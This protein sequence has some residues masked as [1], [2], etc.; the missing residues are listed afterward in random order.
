[1]D[2]ITVPT[3]LVTTIHDTITSEVYDTVTVD[4]TVTVV[5]SETSTV[6]L[7]TFRKRATLAELPFYA[8]TCSRLSH[9]ASACS[10]IGVTA[11]TIFASTPSATLV[12]TVTETSLTSVTQVVETISTTVEDTTITQTTTDATAT[13]EVSV[14]VTPTP[15]AQPISGYLEVTNEDNVFL[16]YPYLAPYTNESTTAV[17]TPSS[18]TPAPP[19]YILEPNGQLSTG[20]QIAGYQLSDYPS[21]MLAFYSLESVPGAIPYTCKLD[22][23]N[24]LSC[25]RD[26]M[27]TPIL[28]MYYTGNGGLYVGTSVASFVGS[29]YV[30]VTLRLVSSVAG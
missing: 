18:L 22:A 7:A 28:I 4:Q 15:T 25:Y 10:C 9:Y 3:T 17:I 5:A 2:T 30:P 14:T 8:T 11:K 27:D 19:I 24:Y 29:G 23:A 12:I 16:G 13:V 21:M 20:T 26:G 6:D 1:M